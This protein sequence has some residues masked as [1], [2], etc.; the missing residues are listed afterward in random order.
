DA[1]GRRCL[2]EYCEDCIAWCDIYPQPD[3]RFM[4][5]GYLTAWPQRYA[6]VHIV[7]H[8]GVNLA[9]WR[10]SAHILE[11]GD[12]IRVDAFPLIFYHFTGLFLDATGVWRSAFR[13]FGDNLSV[14]VDA[15]Y[16]P[17]V[18]EVERTDSELRRRL[19]DLP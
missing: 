6:N 14:A 16:Q 8:P 11:R 3:G 5:Q 4:D 19:P 13:D 17:Y 18:T 9:W 10:V 7:R 1:E 2:A 15:I 12:P